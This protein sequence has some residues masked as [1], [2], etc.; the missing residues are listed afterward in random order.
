MQRGWRAHVP[1]H[2]AAPSLP[3]RAHAHCPFSPL[4]ACTR[5]PSHP[6]TP[7]YNTQIVVKCEQRVTALQQEHLAEMSKRD[8]LLQRAKDTILRLEAQ[9]AGAW[10]AW[11]GHAGLLEAMGRLPRYE[12]LS[13]RTLPTTHSHTRTR[14]QSASGST[15]T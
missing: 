1:L 10:V 4:T 14:A 3:T 13:T 9:Y 8:M 11:Q 12:A 2:A 6:P 7:F 5:A 15:W